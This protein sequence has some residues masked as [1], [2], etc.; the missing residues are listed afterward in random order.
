ML[1]HFADLVGL[2]EEGVISQPV[3]KEIFAR[4]KSDQAAGESGQYRSGASGGQSVPGY[5]KEEGIPENSLTETFVALKVEVDKSMGKGKLIDEIFGTKVE[6]HLIQPTF[7]IDYPVEMSPLCKKHRNN[8]E[9]TEIRKTD[10]ELEEIS[11]EGKLVLPAFCDSHTHLVYA[12][13]REKEYEDKIRGLSYE[14][15]A[16]V[17]DVPIGTVRSRLARARRALRKAVGR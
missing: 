15:I 1:E 10:T 14:E 16:E 17:L 7:I 6:D 12:G 2:R 13:S 4:M 9:L 8:P 11:A 5:L 3:A